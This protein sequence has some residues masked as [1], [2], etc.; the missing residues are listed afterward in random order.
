MSN[1][2]L[3]TSIEYL[4]GVGPAKA[5]LLKKELGIFTFAQLLDYYPFRYIDKS[6]IY[7]ISEINSDA[8][9]IQLKGK[10]T[11]IQTIGD[12]RAKRM[13]AKFHD[14]TGEIDLVW[15][16]GIKWLSSSIKP[17]VEYIVYGKPT[18]FKNTYNITHPEL[19]LVSDSLLANKITLESVYHT[20]EKLSAKGLNAKGI[21]K[22]QKNLTSQLR[23]KIIETLPFELIEKLNLISKEAAIINAHTPENEVLLQK[24]LFRLKFEELFYLQLNLL[25]QKVIKAEKIKGHVF[26]N[27]GDNFNTFYKNNLAFELTDAQ[28]R[29]I[30]EIRRDVGA[31]EHMNRLLQGDVG[32]GKT[33]VA[34]LTML[35]AIDN[36]FQTCLMAPT[37][38][39]ASQHYEGLMEMLEGMNVTIE[40]LTGSVKT[41]KRRQIHEDLENGTLKIL[42]GT[43]A[44]LEDKVKFDNLGYVVI[45]EQHRFGVQQRS[46]LWRKGRAIPPHVLVMTATPIPRTLAMTFYG[47]LD[48]SVIDELPP[49]RKPITTT[50]R[51]DSA[52]MRVFGF[53]EEEIK[54]GRQIYVVYPLINESEK[55]DYKDLMDGFES[56]SRRF[57]SPNY[58]I[59]IVHGKMKPA[60]KEYEMQRF[61]K[62]E[63]QIMVATTVIEVGVNVPNAS[64]MIIESAERFG[65]SQLHQLRGRVGRGAEQSYCI[66]MTGNKLSSDS[67]LRM[68]TMVRT[69]DGFEIAEV[70]LKLRGPGDIQGTQQSGL[71]NLNIA[72][73]AKDGQVL[74]MARNEAIEVLKK[75]PKLQ[76][77]NNHRLVT[78]LDNMKRNKVN[79]S[80]IS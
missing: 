67:K 3:D 77:E 74:Q 35:I 19:D 56:I 65:L 24:A 21:F 66:L 73:L 41:A 29:V 9:F 60:D 10:I 68:E 55:M 47:D 25:Q 1:Q 57:P 58:N 46:K 48:I 26:G 71:L 43:H 20:T 79:W 4:K 8:A 42:V 15:F 53:M 28:K 51:F 78:G 5:E 50:H 44:L 39:L 63:T 18:L 31:G 32:S 12:K 30:K 49:G 61:V 22:I 70:D 34:L 23:G 80:R 13:V 45:D 37:E 17:N 59:S 14:E 36:G 6:K 54:K 27:V 40:L 2:F 52:R 64:V 11:Q 16:K 72:D 62:G 69:N 38:I 75:D 33:V 7:K 76:S